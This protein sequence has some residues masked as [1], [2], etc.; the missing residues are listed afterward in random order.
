M[1]G[2]IIDGLG[3]RRRMR[4]LR[5]WYAANKK[6]EAKIRTDSVKV[7]RLLLEWKKF[8]ESGINNY[9]ASRARNDHQDAIER[10]DWMMRQ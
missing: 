9:E 6:H 5:N 10:L 7:T 8:E 2:D 3:L 4:H 1:I